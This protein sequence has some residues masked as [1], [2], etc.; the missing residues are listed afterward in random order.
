LLSVGKGGVLRAVFGLRGI[1]DAVDDSRRTV[2]AVGALFA[3]SAA[4][5]RFALVPLSTTDLTGVLVG[6]ALVRFV[7]K[8]DV[9]N[10][11]DA[12]AAVERTAAGVRATTVVLGFED[13]VVVDVTGVLVG[14][15][16]ADATA[17]DD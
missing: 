1:L 9:G 13:F 4:N 16:E 10:C 17:F 3:D 5:G 6:T 11:D 2:S 14:L 15:R 12:D 8:F 7:G